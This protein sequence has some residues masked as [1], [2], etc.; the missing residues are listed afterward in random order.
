[1]RKLTQTFSFGLIAALALLLCAARASAQQPKPAVA[2]EVSLAGID[3]VDASMKRGGFDGYAPL[4]TRLLE[5]FP[6]TGNGA[7]DRTAPV[8]IYYLAGDDL[9]P[10]AMAMFLIP[11]KADAAQLKTF[12]EQGWQGMPGH[13]D[14]VVAPNDFAIR[15]TAGHLVAGGN[16]QAVA[17]VAADKLGA[18]Y[19]EP[20]AF[21]HVHVSVATFRAASPQR[22]GGFLDGIKRNDAAK[23]PGEAFGQQLVLD[24]IGKSLDTLDITL[25]ADADH[26]TTRARVAPVAL[27]P[28]AAKFPRPAFP[29]G[30][31]GRADLVYP[32]ADTIPL[33]TRMVVVSHHL[34]GNDA[35]KSGVIDRELPAALKP[36]IGDAISLGFEWNDGALVTYASTQ[37]AD[38]P[39]VEGALKRIAERFADL[40]KRSTYADGDLTV[41]RMTAVDNGKTIFHA[42]FVPDGKRLTVAFC[43]RDGKYVARA[44]R[45]KPAGEISGLLSSEVD[46]PAVR[47][48]VAALPAGTLDADQKR[49]ADLFLKGDKV[50]FSISN[51]G[52]A[53]ETKLVGPISWLGSVMKM[54]PLQ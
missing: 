4:M 27:K 48:L 43:A 18:P 45:L 5:G 52:Q 42:D 2:A 41:T 15:R 10:Q 46:L 9:A 3:P 51:D 34:A 23:N 39:D 44:A 13:A 12:R 53:L 31:L 26:I 28:V 36:L 50:T 33:I 47:K 1:M 21:G 7:L 6:F 32:A 22:F 54:A 8:G 38:A 49:M 20:G 16:S 14:T 17:T 29:D 40:F 30:C 37:F 11:V 25:L 19:K 35:E 24:W